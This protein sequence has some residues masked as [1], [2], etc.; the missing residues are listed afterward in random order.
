MAAIPAHGLRLLGQLFKRAG[1]AEGVRA[2]DKVVVT[3]A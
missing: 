3:G 2:I 1:T